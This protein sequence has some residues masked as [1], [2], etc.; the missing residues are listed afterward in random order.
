[1][2]TIMKPVVPGG[3]IGGDFSMGG[4]GS[5]G[6]QMGPMGGVLNGDGLDGMKNSPANGSTGGGGAGGPG[7]PRD[8]SGSGMG[9]Y[10][11]GGFGSGGGE[12]VRKK[13]F[14]PFHIQK[15]FVC[16]QDQTESAAILK[17]KESMQEEAKRFEKDNDQ[18]DYYMQ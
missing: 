10:N 7:T 16:F 14:A 15:T 6:S 2:Y 12:N 8:D 4:G 18:P 17:I 1:M 3:N 9:D 11:L 5:D 13:F